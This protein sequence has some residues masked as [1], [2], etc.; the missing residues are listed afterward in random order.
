VAAKRLKS[1]ARWREEWWRA[2]LPAGL[3][4]IFPPR[5]ARTPVATPAIRVFTPSLTHA[6]IDRDHAKPREKKDAIPE[7]RIHLLVPASRLWILQTPEWQSYAAKREMSSR[8][9]VA[10][11]SSSFETMASSFPRDDKVKNIVVLSSA[12]A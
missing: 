1:I 3:G 5:P 12:K 2:S 4:V 11:C 9:R 10:T 8:E 7:P 6:R